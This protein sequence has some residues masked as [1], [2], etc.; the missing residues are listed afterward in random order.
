MTTATTTSAAAAAPRS[1]TREVYCGNSSYHQCCSLIPG[2]YSLKANRDGLELKYIGDSTKV[3]TSYYSSWPCVSYTYNTM[4]YCDS[5]SIQYSR[6]T[7]KRCFIKAQGMRKN[8]S[9]QYVWITVSS[10]A[11]ITDREGEIKLEVSDAL[12][13]YRWIIEQMNTDGSRPQLVLEVR[14]I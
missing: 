11:E 5:Q 9:K 4:Y 1:P 13:L 12:D 3:S 10:K 8:Q 7:I 6:V 14:M 2:T